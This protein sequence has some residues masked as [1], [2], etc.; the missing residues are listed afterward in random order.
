MFEPEVR[1]VDYERYSNRQLATV[2]LVV[3]ALALAVIVGWYLT[4]GA[5]AALGI[6]F[7]GGTEPRVEAPGGPDAIQSAF[8]RDVNSIRTISGAEDTYVVT[9]QATG[10]DAARELE[11]RAESSGLTVLSTQSTSASFA[12]QTQLLAL[13]GVGVAFVGM[14][15]MVFILFRTAI[16]SLAVVLSAFGDIVVPV[17]VMNLVGIQLSLGTVAALLMLIGYSVDS[18]ILLN[19]HVLRRSG[20]FYESAYRAMRTGVTMTLTSMSAAI[21]MAIVASVFG[22]G[23]LAAI[24]TVLA[25]G[26]GVDLVNTYLLNLSL[27]RWYR[28]LDA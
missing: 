13:G 14:S 26:L 10:T 11:A 23:L 3:L 4:T 6:E 24:G 17:A 12:G 16:P 21:V 22:I 27:L 1:R 2:P 5:P 8:D 15:V 19:N 28:G 20:G 7:T 9:F 25:I 18:D